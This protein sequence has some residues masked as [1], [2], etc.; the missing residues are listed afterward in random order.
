[1][2]NWKWISQN[3][4]PKLS[5]ILPSFSSQ[6]IAVKECAIKIGCFQFLEALAVRAVAARTSAGDEVKLPN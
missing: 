2:I 5:A 6:Q 3:R 4:D 1:M